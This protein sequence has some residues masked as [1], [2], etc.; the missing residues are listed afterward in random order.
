MGIDGGL[1][2]YRAALPAASKKGGLGFFR[3]F[4]CRWVMRAGVLPWRTG[5]RPFGN[6]SIQ[7][8]IH[9]F[10]RN[11]VSGCTGFSG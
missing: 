6:A 10:F 9:D 2:V 5:C 4:L 1:S 7:A 11:L 8:T 3:N